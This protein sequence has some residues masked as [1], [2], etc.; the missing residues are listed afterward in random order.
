MQREYPS[1]PF[2]RYCDDAVAHCRSESEAQ[3][4]LTAIEQRLQECKLQMHPEKSG[5]VC[6]NIADRRGSYPRIQFTFLGYTFRPRRTKLPNG[7]AWTGFRHIHFAPPS[8]NWRCKSLQHSPGGLDEAACASESAPIAK[9][10]L[11]P[12]CWHPRADPSPDPR[13]RVGGAKWICLTGFLPAVS[14]AAIQRINR[15]IR[16]WH[17]PRQTSASLNELAMRYNAT[18][19]GWLNYYGRFYLSIGATTSL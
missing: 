3:A 15:T 8:S 10:G 14:A 1:T 13:L 11:A 5:V 4:L 7:K 2:A 6:C 19:R 9:T 12:R 18:L 16:E 17:L